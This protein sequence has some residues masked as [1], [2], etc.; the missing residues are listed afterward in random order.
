MID[1]SLNFKEKEL[2]PSF[3]TKYQLDA[4]LPGDWNFQLCIR[5][6]GS[7]FS[8][9]EIG[10]RSFDLED[11]FFSD[12]YR[13]N[14]YA[15]SMRIEYLR[16]RQKELRDNRGNADLRAEKKRD[17]E[18][19]NTELK[20]YEE[21]FKSH[22]SQKKETPIEYSALSLPGKFTMQGSVE[23]LLQV[24]EPDEAREVEMPTLEP[25]KPQKFEIRLIIWDVNEVPIEGKKALKL[26]MKATMNSEGW[27]T[28]GIEKL[29]DTH[30]GVEDGKGQFNYRM[31][32]PLTLP[33]A[34]PRIKIESFDMST[35]GSDE[36]I[37]SVTFE[38]GTIT[39]KLETEG[40]FDSKTVNL[41]MKE[42]TNGLYAGTVRI[43]IKIIP[44]EEAISN[45]VG[46]AQDAP[47]HDPFLEKPGGRGAG[48]YL[49]SIDFSFLGLAY[50]LGTVKYVGM[51]IGL[52]LIFWILF[53]SPGI[54][55]KGK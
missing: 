54:I 42:A 30:L 45:P 19:I 14:S 33:C 38:L 46:E 13:I 16:K 52:V 7:M 22:I 11:R 36:A 10:I 53:I 21:I 40:R 37:G 24:L 8:N 17:I 26:F 25:P 9:P 41:K 50:L 3:F 48:D 44:I 5:H 2:N 47:N 49:K 55:T 35:V 20:K 23:I 4:F 15:Y 12:E 31:L 6:K 27:S 32:F 39:K 1:D 43:S 18:R 51:G 29:T 28:E 34:F